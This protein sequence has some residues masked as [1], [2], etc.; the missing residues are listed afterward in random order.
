MYLEKEIYAADE[1]VYE[2][3]LVQKNRI[4]VD[5][6]WI[7]GPG[8]FRMIGLSESQMQA[9]TVILTNESGT[10]IIQILCVAPIKL[11]HDDDIVLVLS[12][13][14]DDICPSVDLSNISPIPFKSVH[15]TPSQLH[16]YVENYHTVLC[17]RGCFPISHFLHVLH[18]T[19]HLHL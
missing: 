11:E 13:S 18:Y 7:S 10:S 9:S 12:S 8:L 17:T 15:S 6:M 5:F 19:L 14:E 4:E 3:I 1:E 16:V 2:T